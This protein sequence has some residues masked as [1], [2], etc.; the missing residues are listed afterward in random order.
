MNRIQRLV[1]SMALGVLLA[2]PAFAGT[3]LSDV[4]NTGNGSVQANGTLL[5]DGRSAEK[6]ATASSG[7]IWSEIMATALSVI[8]T[9]SRPSN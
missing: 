7:S 9:I 3:L 5:S 1:G 8:V 2:A 4:R 6:E